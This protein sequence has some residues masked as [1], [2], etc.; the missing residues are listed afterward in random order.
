MIDSNVITVDQLIGILQRLPP[1]LEVW[2]GDDNFHRVPIRGQ[3]HIE[4]RND[5]FWQVDPA[6]PLSLGTPPEKYVVIG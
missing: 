1:H 5:R 3:L 4:E 2:K 6:E